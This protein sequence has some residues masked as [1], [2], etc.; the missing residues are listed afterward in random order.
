V[1]TNVVDVL[2]EELSLRSWVSETVAIGTATDPYQPI[3]GK[4]RFTARPELPCP[5]RSRGSKDR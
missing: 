3:E 2:K 4:Y 5:D 1:K